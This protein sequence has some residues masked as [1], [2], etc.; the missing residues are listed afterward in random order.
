MTKKISFRRIQRVR[1]WLHNLPEATSLEAFAQRITPAL[2]KAADT[3]GLDPEDPYHAAILLR[4]LAGLVFSPGRKGRPHDTPKWD[5][6]R[7]FDLG[8]HFHLL[9]REKPGIKISEAA[10]AIK[11]RWPKEYG[12]VARQRCGKGSLLRT[13]GSKRSKKISKSRCRNN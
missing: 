3:F 13:T 8:Y 11:L 1:D 2:K 10:K 12:T 7:E 4:I 5:A 6:Q 9:R